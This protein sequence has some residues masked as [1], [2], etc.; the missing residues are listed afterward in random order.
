MGTPGPHMPG[1][2]GTLVPVYT[3]RRIDTQG[4]HFPRNSYGDPL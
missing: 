1:K 3:T 2:M 4:P